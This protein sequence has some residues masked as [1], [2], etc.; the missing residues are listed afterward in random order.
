MKLLIS[1]CSLSLLAHE[2]GIF[3]YSEEVNGQITASYSGS[4]CAKIP[5]HLVLRPAEKV[6]PILVYNSAKVSL[7]DFRLEQVTHV[8]LAKHVISHKI[9]AMHKLQDFC[10][11]QNQTKYCLAF[12]KV[13]NANCKLK[14][15]VPSDFTSVGG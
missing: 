11:Q 12:T 2:S 13:T 6:M 10:Y 3:N 14:V 8:N 15:H 4:V 5:G 1:L 9:R 7:I